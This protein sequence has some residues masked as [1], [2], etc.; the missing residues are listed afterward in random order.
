LRNDVADRSGAEVSMLSGVHRTQ[1]AT[2]SAE[3]FVDTGAPRGTVKRSIAIARDSIRSTSENDLDTPWIDIGRN[4]ADVGQ[5]SATIAGVSSFRR[6][7]AEGDAS[8]R[9]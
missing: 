9:W 2:P 4:H 7:L 3:K 5:I 1:I 6:V 8:C